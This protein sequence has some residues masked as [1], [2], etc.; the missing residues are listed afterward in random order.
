MRRTLLPLLLALAL[1]AIA[2]AGWWLKRPAE[3]VA[4]ACADPLAGCTFSH[5]GQPVR[6]R[7]SAVPVPLE[8]FALEVTAAHVR[9]VSAEF[10]MVGM[11]MGFNRY[12]LH[13]RDGAYSARVTLPVCVSGRH[14]WTL[15]LTLD[16]RRYALPF[17]SR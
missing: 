3:A 8:A 17:S 14:D 16:D 2:V 5:A 13:G 1:I 10:Q 12:D 7:F 9:R 6:V 15:Y 11:D 4:V